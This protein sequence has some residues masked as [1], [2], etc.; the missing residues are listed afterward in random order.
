M[1]SWLFPQSLTHKGANAWIN[2]LTPLALAIGLRWVLEPVLQDKSPFLLFTLGVMAAGLYGG[3]RV[4]ITASAIG[5]VAG[6][7]FR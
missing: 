3:A 7:V 5:G 4:G 6:C 1:K 2:G